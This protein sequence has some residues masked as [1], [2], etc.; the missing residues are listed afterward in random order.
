MGSF[1]SETQQ[2]I[3]DY[4]GPRLVVV[5]A[6][7]TGKTATIVERMK[8]L[9]LEDPSRAVS[10]LTFTRASRRDTE[11][12]V[13]GA[14]AKEP[15]EENKDFGLPLAATLHGYAK[16]LVHRYAK[17]LGFADENIRV[18]DE[19]M[20][21]TDLILREVIH[22]LQL[23]VQSGDLHKAVVCYRCT[24]FW[25]DWI[26]LSV[27]LRQAAIE[28]FDELLRFYSAMDMEGF[29]WSACDVLS[30]GVSD[31]PPLYL[32]VDEY[33]D[34]NPKDQKLVELAGS[35]ER[36]LVVVVGDDAQSIYSFRH[37]NPNGIRDLWEASDWSHESLDV[38][39]RLPPHIL[40]AANA[41]IAKRGYLGADVQL[42]DDD[43][44]RV[45]TLQCTK[46]DIQPKA[47]AKEIRRRM[48]EAQDATDDQLKYGDFMIL[49]PNSKQVAQT[50]E[51]LSALDIPTKTANKETMAPSVWN[52]LLVL[53]MLSD[54]DSLALRQW[55]ENM[56]LGFLEAVDLRKA[57]IE[58]NQ[59][60]FDLCAS[61][62]DP[63]I[64]QVFDGLSRLKQCQLDP[65]KFRDELAKIPGLDP[66]DALWS[67]VDDSLQHLPFFGRMITHIRELHGILESGDVPEGA[68]DEEEGVL[69]ATMHASKGL[70]AAIV[71]IAWMN[72]GFMPSGGRD[73]LEEERV[74][75]V[76]L[77]R[78]KQD[79][80]LL[81]YEKFDLD[82]RR[83]L[84][85]E[86]MSPF[87]RSIRQHLDVRR[88]KAADV[89]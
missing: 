25:P 12:K 78:A 77:T 22:D 9:L 31:L 14:V 35:L 86:A 59:S 60:L 89:K 55:L 62:D 39:Y 29:V 34:L 15:S 17:W 7:G 79:V 21:E 40:R 42:P 10:F 66:D 57:A 70:E 58:S 23:T 76:A 19:K 27:K 72:D 64:M 20:G 1:P 6:P 81:F 32:Q 16:S 85:E 24:G 37:A 56:G 41:L 46:S 44:K 68:D 5:A 33:Q 51:A 65:P 28:A 45:M 82:K 50:V 49:C 54:R 18:L 87:L 47:I 43:G 88:V 63:R 8:A 2:R 83:P 11:Q 52:F 4:R 84:K 61:R 30:K 3:I 74:L 48:A 69:V 36:S 26:E 71:F 75:Y 38:C 53:R 73:I 13:S 80:I 67:V